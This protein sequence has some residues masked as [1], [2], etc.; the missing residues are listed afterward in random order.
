M[1][2]G[3]NAG[4]DSG[5]NFSNFPAPAWQNRQEGSELLY[6]RIIPIEKAPKEFLVDGPASPCHQ[7]PAVLCLISS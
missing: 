3:G 2:L 1:H 6:I 7:Y 5:A 4:G